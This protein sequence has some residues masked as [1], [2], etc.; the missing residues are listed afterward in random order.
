MY[1]VYTCHGV[2]LKVG[3]QPVGVGSLFPPCVAWG[4]ALLPAEPS[5]WPRLCFR[6]DCDGEVVKAV[7]RAG[8]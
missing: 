6:K 2:C 8:I 5:C 7:L 1:V 4:Q 3:G